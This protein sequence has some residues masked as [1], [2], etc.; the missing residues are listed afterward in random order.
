MRISHEIVEKHG[1]EIRLSSALGEGTTVT[2][3]VPLKPTSSNVKFATNGDV[4]ND[5]EAQAA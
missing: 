2:F 4:T 1:G 5:F 3:E